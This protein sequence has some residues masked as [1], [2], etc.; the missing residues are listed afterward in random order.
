MGK[1]KGMVAFANETRRKSTT[2]TRI[3]QQ[4][5]PLR[6]KGVGLMKVEKAIYK[7]QIKN[8]D[9]SVSTELVAT[10]QTDEGR[11]K[12]SGGW[13]NTPL[14]Y[15]GKKHTPKEAQANALKTGNRT[16]YYD[17]VDDALKAERKRHK[18]LEK[19]A[20]KAGAF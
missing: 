9:G 1:K 6:K 16:K 18:A 7:P 8:K 3:P 19:K 11:K 5:K 17:T 13:Y 4:D 2:T 12:G 20:K 10:F 15:D 14:I